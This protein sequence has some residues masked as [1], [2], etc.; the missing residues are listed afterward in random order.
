MGI[1]KD[2][3]HMKKKTVLVG[4]KINLLKLDLK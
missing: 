1:S 3:R 2:S 4:K